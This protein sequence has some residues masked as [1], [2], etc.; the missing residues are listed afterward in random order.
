M[1]EIL[2]TADPVRL[3]FATSVLNGAG[4]DCSV[5]G[6]EMA[7][8]YAGVGLFTPRLMVDDEEADEARRVLDAAFREVG[9]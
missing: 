8:L 6:R 9:E 5:L 1:K 7:N 3:S 4:I 2:R